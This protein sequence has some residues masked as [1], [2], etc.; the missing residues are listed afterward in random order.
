MLFWVMNPYQ[1]CLQAKVKNKAK[2]GT[3]N[4][5]ESRPK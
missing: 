3:C 1:R 4:A 2:I 5:K